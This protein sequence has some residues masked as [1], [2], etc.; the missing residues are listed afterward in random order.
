MLSPALKQHVGLSH[1]ALPRRIKPALLESVR[2]LRE[3]Q[4]ISSR[5]NDLYTGNLHGQEVVIKF[6]NRNW[7]HHKLTNEAAVMSYLGASGIA[8]V[9]HIIGIGRAPTSV[10]LPPRLGPHPY[11]MVMQRIEGVPWSTFPLES[12]HHERLLVQAAEHVRN[13]RTIKADA[14][15]GF[16]LKSEVPCATNIYEVSGMLSAP[17]RTRAE[18]IKF[19]GE[20]YLRK[21]ALKWSATERQA[22]GFDKQLCGLCARALHESATWSD[23]N[24]QLFPLSHLDFARKNILLDHDGRNIVAVLDWEWAGFALPEFEY[25]AGCDFLRDQADAK[26]FCTLAGISQQITP[27]C[28]TGNKILSNLFGLLACDEWRR[29]KV[30][31]TARFLSDKREQ[32]AMRTHA[33][34]VST[35]M[36][37]K[38]EN[39]RDLLA[40]IGY[41]APC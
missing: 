29:D 2:D 31:N 40:E 18:Y 8:P 17:V 35:V 4:G 11:Y 36:R 13:L 16:S 23:N 22:V 33:Y 27:A 32:A 5:V 19:I 12:P 20:S 6:S 25:F 7:D 34:P 28:A 26:T 9:P 10:G 37:E 3:F 41:K 38:A 1:F 15:G 24:Q 14:L 39:L 21:I 30:S